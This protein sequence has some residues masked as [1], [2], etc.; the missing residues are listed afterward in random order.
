[1][2]KRLFGAVL[3]LPLIRATCD[4]IMNGKCSC[5]P[6]L[7]TGKVLFVVNCTDAGFTNTKPLEHLPEETEVSVDDSLSMTKLNLIVFQVLIFTGN[8]IT[9]LPWNVFGTLQTY[10]KLGVV[11]MSNNQIQEVLGKAY[12]RVANVQ[13]LILN[14]NKISIAEELHHPRMFSNFVNLEEL[15]LTN[16][17]ADNSD[18]LGID[19]HDIF[20]SSNLTKL[21]KLHLEQNEVI[22]FK[23][24]QVFCDLPK[25]M[26]LHLGDNRLKGIDFE[27]NCL[28][29]LRFIDLEGNNITQLSN[30]ELSALDALPARNQTLTI[31][32]T[33]NPF[34]CECGNNNLFDWL[35]K[36]KVSVRK[37]DALRCF[38]LEGGLLPKHPVECPHKVMELDSLED[39]ESRGVPIALILLTCAALFVAIFLL[40]INWSSIR[41]K[42][43][44]RVETISRKVHYSSIGHNDDQ[45]IDV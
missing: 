17:F 20:V 9:E 6:A 12:H 3:L 19:L 4:P 30:E 2:L 39:Y 45:E 42:L 37:A 8:N 29:N 11:D 22:S 36:T 23:D 21:L 25:L 31:D 13:R 24:K 27:I 41:H 1:M 18:N 14:H 15:H 40:Y 28:K 7:Y 26:D 33:D 38:R 32:L 10:S 16:A 43:H 44:P 34:S 35:P 5:G